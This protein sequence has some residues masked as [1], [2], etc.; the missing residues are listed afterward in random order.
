MSLLFTS[1]HGGRLGNVLMS[2]AN[3]ILMAER[4]NRPLYIRDIGGVSGCI[5]L[6]HSCYEPS[7]TYDPASTDAPRGQWRV[8]LHDEEP[9]TPV[10]HRSNIQA[11]QS[12][13]PIFLRQYRAILRDLL[14]PRLRA[15]LSKYGCADEPA[16]PEDH[17]VIHVRSGDIMQWGEGKNHSSYGQP[18]L[19]YYRH[20]VD[21]HDYARVTIVTEP[22][23]GNPVLAALQAH[24]GDKI[25]IQSRSV[26]EDVALILRARHVC[27]GTGTF[28]QALAYAS[29]HIVRLHCFQNHVLHFPEA[30]FDI[31]V[32]ETT[33]YPMHAVSRER[34]EQLCQQEWTIRERDMSQVKERPLRF[35]DEH[36]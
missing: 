33:G 9:P 35:W 21:A 15:A 2:T 18:P 1:P 29:R 36:R 17:L 24:Y 32:H 6:E 25:Q 3:M 27:A 28:A 7:G 30:D 16:L 10:V 11:F 23:R 5:D 4:H 34:F 20:V 12:E 19:A 31:R 13:T 22:D 14:A 8:W 26:H